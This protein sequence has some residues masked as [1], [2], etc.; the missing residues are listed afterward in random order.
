MF[1]VVGAG[2]SRVQSLLA[3]ICIHYRKIS[4]ITNMPGLVLGLFRA[5]NSSRGRLKM[6]A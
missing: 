3:T 6:L 1:R 2:A 5:L 4:E